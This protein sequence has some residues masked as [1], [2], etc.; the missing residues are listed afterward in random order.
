MGFENRDYA[1]TDDRSYSSPRSR[2]SII[3]WIIT[4]NIAVFVVQCIWT[5]PA[6]VDFSGVF[7]DELH[8]PRKMVE[9]P[10]IRVSVLQEWFALDRSA[11]QKGQIWRL[12]T[13]DLLH[14]TQGDVPWHLFFNMYLLY[15]LGRKIVD[16]HSEREFLCRYIASAVASGVVY[17]LWG[18]LMKEDHPAIGA[19]GAV[20]AVL[21]IYAMRWP[22][23][24]WTLFYVVPVTA[25][26]MVILYA[27]FD[28][29]PMLKQLGGHPD[30]TG[31]GH[32]AHLGGMLFGFLYEY[33]H[34]NME[35][36][37]DN[38]VRW[39]PLKRRPKLRVVRDTDEPSHPEL[40]PR[41]SEA[42]LQLRLDELLAK[43]TEQGQASLT[44]SE[45]NELNEA[46]RYFRERR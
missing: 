5:R 41:R 10:N 21:V 38:L 3:G 46:S 28:A 40:R 24:V 15:I 19:S 31:V 35:S 29:Y 13:Y 18:L 14:S 32:S 11:I 6:V 44:E 43:I 17:L 42:Q 7:R 33:Y 16:V 39:N 30:M 9:L 8:D 22:N 27:G 26:W 36:Q 20:S 4:V 45:R 1:R 12:A 2:M 25:K 37:W 34:W 23:D